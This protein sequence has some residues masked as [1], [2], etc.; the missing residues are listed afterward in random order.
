MFLKLGNYL[1]TASMCNGLHLSGVR[2]ANSVIFRANYL[3][4][5]GVSNSHYLR[6]RSDYLRRDCN[7][8]ARITLRAN[9]SL[10]NFQ[11]GTALLELLA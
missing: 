6:M 3:R 7:H 9:G 5:S 11:G 10:D 8:P 4:L 1:L 2:I